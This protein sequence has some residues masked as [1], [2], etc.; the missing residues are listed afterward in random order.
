MRKLMYFLKCNSND[1]KNACGFL[2]AYNFFLSYYIDVRN[3]WGLVKAYITPTRFRDSTFNDSLIE[4]IGQTDR[5]TDMQRMHEQDTA[6]D[7]NWKR[8]TERLI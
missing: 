3:N 4:T 2:N 6:L 5:Q 8:G 7:R 1:K